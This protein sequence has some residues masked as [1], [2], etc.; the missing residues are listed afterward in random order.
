MH[1]DARARCIP[2][3]LP[4]IIFY[5]VSAELG[6]IP[7]MTTLKARHFSWGLSYGVRLRKILHSV[8]KP[9]KCKAVIVEGAIPG[10]YLISAKS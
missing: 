1:Q 3:L 6:A 5:F 7:I 2:G 10:R 4:A 9:E 8:K